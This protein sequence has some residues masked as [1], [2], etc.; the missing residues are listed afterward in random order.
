[1]GKA[2]NRR[3]VDRPQD[4]DTRSCPFCHGLME[5]QESLQ[6]DAQTGWFCRCGNSILL[7]QAIN[8]SMAERRRALDERRAKAFR[9]SMKVRARAN[10]LVKKAQRLRALRRR[11]KK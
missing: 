4:G 8:L 7:R 2:R 5:F 9:R 10:E 6:D 11:E 3:A 1:M